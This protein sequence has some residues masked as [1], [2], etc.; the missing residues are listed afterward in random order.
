MESAK[1][2][3]KPLFDKPVSFTK[4]FDEK[5]QSEIMR[6]IK[7]DAIICIEQRL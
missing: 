5:K 6:A 3:L 4:L 2:L 1:D 7:N